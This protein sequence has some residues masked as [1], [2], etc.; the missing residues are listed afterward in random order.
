LWTKITRVRK[1]I[2]AAVNGMCLGGGFEIALMCDIIVASENAQFGLP[3]IKL[4]VIP[5]AGGTQRLPRLVGK[6]KAM[7]M[8]LTGAPISAKEAREWHIVSNVFP[9]DK[10]IE[11]SMNIAKKIA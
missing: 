8:I 10:L 3:E 2:I 11:G 6:T 9:N 7:E 4:G 5:G 1:P